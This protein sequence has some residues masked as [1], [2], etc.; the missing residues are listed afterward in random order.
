MSEQ[1]SDAEEKQEITDKFLKSY[2]IAIET[3]QFKKLLANGEKE[4][5]KKNI[6]LKGNW[7]ECLNAKVNEYE[8][9]PIR[10]KG[11]IA[12]FN[13]K[14]KTKRG[15]YFTASALCVEAKECKVKYFFEIVHPPIDKDKAFISV[16]VK[17]DSHHNHNEI[18]RIQIKVP[19]VKRKEAQNALAKFNKLTEAFVRDESSKS[20]KGSVCNSQTQSVYC[21]EGLNADDSHCRV[22]CDSG[23]HGHRSQIPST[24]ESNTSYQNLSRNFVSFSGKQNPYQRARSDKLSMAKQQVEF[25]H[26][27]KLNIRENDKS[28]LADYIKTNLKQRAEE[29]AV[30]A[31]KQELSRVD[32][33]VNV[34]ICNAQN[35]LKA[36]I[37]K[38]LR[39]NN[40][41]L[42][43]TVHDMFAVHGQSSQN[44]V[45]LQN[46]NASIAKRSI[47]VGIFE[48]DENGKLS[49][50]TQDKSSKNASTDHQITFHSDSAT[51]LIAHV[52]SCEASPTSQAKKRRRSDTEDLLA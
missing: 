29:A 45:L 39:I 14:T 36:Q 46:L 22:F 35:A 30:E 23:E 16:Q 3:K 6:K 1:V 13:D 49:C 27:M 11:Q 15:R 9:S 40:A 5:G 21:D 25:N 12:R 18:R 47:S 42:L 20:Q 28:V 26:H 38:Q 4:N 41:R 50:R 2:E 33:L 31:I 19:K 43:A 52:S 24:A 48:Y 7:I 44:S 37:E 32:S 10:L 34:Q 51:D 8:G 17:V